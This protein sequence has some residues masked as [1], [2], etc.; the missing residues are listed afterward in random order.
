MLYLKNKNKN[1]QHYSPLS[2]VPP[3]SS[4]KHP[5]MN[6]HPSTTTDRGIADIRACANGM[7]LNDTAASVIA[8]AME[9][10]RMVSGRMV[11]VYFLYRTVYVCIIA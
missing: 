2:P 11:R 4:T 10:A 9:S 1:P 8:T 7:N 5:I 3:L 6:P